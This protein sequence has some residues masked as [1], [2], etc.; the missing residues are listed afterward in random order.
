MNSNT[1]TVIPWERLVLLDVEEIKKHAGFNAR[2]LD[3]ARMAVTAAETGKA[4]YHLTMLQTYLLGWLD[5]IIDATEGRDVGAVKVH[6][7]D[8][9]PEEDRR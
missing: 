2:H 3:R 1:E 8:P 5:S 6:W 4:L 7:G 9:L